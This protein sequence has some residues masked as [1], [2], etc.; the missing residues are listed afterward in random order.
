MPVQSGGL[1]ILVFSEK[2]CNELENLLS[3]T[4]LLVALIITQ[5]ASLPNAAEIK[6][7]T[8]IITQRKTEQLNNK[9]SKIEGNLNPDTKKVVTQAKEKGASSWLTVLPIKEHGFTLTKNEFRDAIHLCYNKTLKRMPG[10]CP[11]GQNY[12]V[13]HAMNCKRGG[14]IIM[15]YNN[16]R[17]F[18]ANLPKT[19]FNDVEVEPKLQ[20]LTMKS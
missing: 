16:V 20:K 4:A 12:D 11:C 5:A 3:I 7:A 9:S 10:Q 14:F 1:G 15:R 13:T 18:E 19:T 2:T 6:E 8:K 17:D